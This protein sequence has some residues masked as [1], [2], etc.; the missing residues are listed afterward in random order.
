[1][2]KYYNKLTVDTLCITESSINQL[3]NPLDVKVNDSTLLQ[4]TES[5]KLILTST[6]FADPQEVVSKQYVDDNSGGSGILESYKIMWGGK[7]T[8]GTATPQFLFYNGN[9]TS[10][11]TEAVTVANSFY[12]PY[13]SSIR[14]IVAVKG[15][16]ASDAVFD[17]YVDNV[18]VY[19]TTANNLQATFADLSLDINGGSRVH[20]VLTGCSVAPN[21]CF[22]DLYIY[23]SNSL[24]ITVPGIIASSNTQAIPE[25]LKTD[26]P[27]LLTSTK[28][29][30]IL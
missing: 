4:F 28:P 2:S 1:M 27:G 6:V 7:I 15:A 25:V 23:K 19:N 13:N 9:P 3:N 20:V 17:V 22:L 12:V 21:E 30:S 26:T 8:T 14:K 16:I 29:I 10:D 18:S 24:P 5:G 11:T